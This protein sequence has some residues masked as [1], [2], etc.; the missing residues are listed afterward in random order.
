METEIKFSRL[1]RAALKTTLLFLLGFIGSKAVVAQ[2]T[3]TGNVVVLNQPCNSDGKIA[4]IITGGLLPPLNYF[5]FDVYG[6]QH[7]HYNVNALTDTLSGI[8]EPISWITVNES[9]GSGLYFAVNVTT[10]VPPFTIDPAITTDAICPS[11]TGDAQITING[12]TMPSA[13]EWYTSSYLGAGI[14]VGL[15]NP[16][17]LS[18]GQYSYIVTDAS[19]CKVSSLLDTMPRV[20]INNISGISYNV[21]TTPA[22]C[23]NG[24]AA[25]SSLVGGMAPYTY[26]WSNGS[27]ATSISGLSMGYYA[28]TVTDAQGCNELSNV[29]INQSP[30]IGVNSVPTSATCLQHNGSAISFGSGGVPP[31]SYIYSNGMTGQSVT[32][33]EGETSYTVTATDANGCIGNGGFYVGTSSPITATYTSTTSLCTTP[34]G[35][36]TLN[37]YGGTPPYSVVWN[38]LPAATGITLSGVSA[39][40]YYF[41]ITDAVGCIRTGNVTIAPNSVINATASGLNP[42]CPATAGSASVYV[43]GTNPPFTYL[44]SNGSTS[45]TLPAVPVGTYSCLITDNVGCTT[46]KYVSLASTSPIT[47]GISTTASSCLYTADG[48]ALVNPIGGTAPYTY[49]WSNGQTSANA[50]GLGTGFYSVY[51]TDANGC[52]SDH[53]TYINYDPSNNSC[54]CTI[55][56]KVYADLNGNCIYDSGEQGIEHIM[57]HC[58]GFGYCFTD[59]NGDYAFHVPTGSYTISET[60]EYAYP[61]QA[62]QSNAI[63]VNTVS[64]SGCLVPV[65]FANTVTP[66]H[67]LHL[68]TVTYNQPIPGAYCTR[69]LIV[70]NDGTLNESTIQ[71]AHHE[72]GQLNFTSSAPY[73]YTQPYPATEPN[74]YEITSGVAT[75]TP[76]ASNMMYFNYMVPT[77][78]PVGSSVVVSDTITSAAPMSTWAND[79]TPWN[80]VEEYTTYVVGS[81]D[82][83]FK[84]VSPKG[85]GPEGFI[86]TADSVLDYAIHFQN[87]GTYYANEVVVLDT[88]DGDLDW[89]SIR[90]GY[91]DHAYTATLSESGVLKFTFANI[92]LDWQAQSEMGSRGMVTYSIKQKPN[93][94]IGTEIKNSAAIYFDYNEAVITNQTL[95]T[96]HAPD[97]INE[98]VKN[99]S[100]H[101]YPNP[102][103]NEL[104][105]DFSTEENVTGINIYDLQGRLLS[106]EI[107]NKN[108][109]SQKINISN[110]VKGIYFVTLE[111][112]GGERK[113]GKF[114]KD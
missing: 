71:L 26:S 54:Y 95:N 112:E 57:I 83:N 72:D 105:V 100:I 28:I 49:N 56:G 110:L 13:V 114:I 38:T 3:G 92:H 45:A 15:G 30:Y 94:S 40:L 34:T 79:F 19:G 32:G 104:T 53:T 58:S 96:I 99:T 48:S 39:G 20:Y 106:S 47:L 12:G 102:A 22:A 10:M 4:T 44:W 113:T 108:A 91:S 59:A 98:I 16:M 69:G 109:R 101:M 82:P 67:D 27:N 17:T 63:V 70:Q 86:L 76:G 89:S 52:Y 7:A 68:F 103:T 29:Y 75:M 97:G 84:E 73:A 31:Y 21:V 66:I 81:H 23:T 90:L 78:I 88:L 60:V 107:T 33:L 6:N 5:Y 11:L 37:I 61:L 51:V 24:T 87:N 55:A 74:W 64:G 42:V 36:A 35:S 25:V 2:A 1:H 111:K 65:N 8:S 77:N 9:S 62:C 80:N 43:T 46:N 50:S 93:L 18:P 14:F 85:T 41:T